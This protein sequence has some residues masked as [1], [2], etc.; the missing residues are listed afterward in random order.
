M[1]ITPELIISWIGII[2]AGG[3]AGFE[4]FR[5]KKKEDKTVEEQELISSAK[6]FQAQLQLY[7]TIADENKE[8]YIKEKT[9]HNNTR[10][11][12]HDKLLIDQADRSKLEEKLISLEQKPDFT[13]MLVELKRH[14]DCLEP[15]SKGITE[16]LQR[17][18][19]KV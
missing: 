13:E 17:L 1:S 6:L 9:D 11:F 8:L 7:R 12:Y 3:A 18:Q 15:M 19:I 10:T 5:N 14:G 4:R 2:V 16:I